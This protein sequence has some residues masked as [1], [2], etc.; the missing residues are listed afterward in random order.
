MTPL[1]WLIRR[2][3]A[4]IGPT[5]APGWQVIRV[6]REMR[7]TLERRMPVFSAP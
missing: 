5:L 1:G 4:A 6:L 3:E 7:A 2:K